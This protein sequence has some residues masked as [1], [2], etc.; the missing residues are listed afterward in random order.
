M[1]RARRLG[2]ALLGGGTGTV[3]LLLVLIFAGI[4]AL[5]P[6]FFEGPSLMAFLKQAAPLVILA[7]GQ[8]FVIVSGNFDLSVGALVGAQVVIA[9]R[10]IDG[11]ESRTVPVMLVM[12]AFGIGVGLVNGL[13]TTVLKVQSFIT[14]LGMLLV[15]YGAIRL[16]TGGAPTGS[17]SEAFRT[18]GRLGITDVPLVGQIPWALLIM[19]ALGAGAILLMRT[20]FGR[21]LMASGDNELAAKLSGARVDAA[22]TAAFVLSGVS[23]T[24][25]GILIGGFAGVSAQVG[26]GLEFTVITAVVLG[27]VALGGGRGTALAAMAGALAIE[28]LFTLFNQMALPATLRP[29]VQG[30][31]I[32]AAVAYA[33]RRRT[34]PALQTTASPS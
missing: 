9:A 23:A 27:G 26:E 1:T 6:G 30:A 29:A 8:Y 25:A 10:L 18:P 20:R 4:L 2:A 13:I 22:R 5:N 28:A 16:W 11:E 34:R 19:L 7:A 32:I 3:F 12:L 14:T 33:A 15:L 17:L 21:I 31:I 24:V